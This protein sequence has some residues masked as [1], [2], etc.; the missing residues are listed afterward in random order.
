MKSRT[1]ILIIL[2][3]FGINA[4]ERFNAVKQ[5][6]MPTFTRLMKQYPHTQLQASESFVGLPKGFMGNSEVGHLNIGAGRVVFQ[7]FSL[8]SRA[9]ETGEFFDNPVFL[10]LFEQMKGQKRGAA[11]H[12][13]GLLSDGGVHSHLTHL[14]QSD[15]TRE[16]K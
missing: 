2:D 11:L 8:I 3:G 13:M 14:F 1:G 12:L 5:A 9:I 10:K 6:K 16:K 15:P 4:S 7:D